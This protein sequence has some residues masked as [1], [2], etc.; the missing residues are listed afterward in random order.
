V[1]R[2][3]LGFQGELLERAAST[4]SKDGAARGLGVRRRLDELDPTGVE[5]ALLLL[6]GRHAYDGP[7]G[8]T[9]DV[10]A[11]LLVDAHAATLG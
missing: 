11:H 9:P 10:H 8:G 6:E 4:Q 5:L 1:L 7:R 3:A 2:F